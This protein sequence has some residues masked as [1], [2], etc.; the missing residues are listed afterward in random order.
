SINNDNRT[1][2]N[3]TLTEEYNL[4]KEYFSF[5][6]EDFFKMNLDAIE[7]AFISEKEKENYKKIILDYLKR[8]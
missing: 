7:Y 6:K 4:L 5:T 3:I 1:V 8:P 2:S